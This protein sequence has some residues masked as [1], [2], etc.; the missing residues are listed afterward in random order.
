ML[1][2]VLKI[3]ALISGA[4]GLAA[5]LFA[6]RIDRLIGSDAETIVRVVGIGLVAFAV[7][8]Y[9]VSKAETSALRTGGWIITVADIA[10]VI[11][12]IAAVAAG[13]F[14]T[15]G[16]LIVLGVAAVVAGF[17]VG[18]IIGLRQLDSDRTQAREPVARA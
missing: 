15:S 3:N 12:S 9:V 11:A 14:N 18:E 6:G 5:A 1:R 17:A 7:V 13:W 2:T 10:W 16:N 4:T 8:L